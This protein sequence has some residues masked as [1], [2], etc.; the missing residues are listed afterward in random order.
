MIKAG[1]WILLMGVNAAVFATPVCEEPDPIM[2][3]ATIILTHSSVDRR[4]NHVGTFEFRNHAISPAVEISASRDGRFAGVSRPQAQVEFKDLNGTWT[5]LDMPVEEFVPG[6][7][8][9]RVAAGATATF[10]IMLFPKNLVRRDGSD[11]RVVVRLANPDACVV[12]YPFRAA[13]MRKPVSGF[14]S[15]PIP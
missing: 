5:V 15:L 11:F 4:G 2:P 7:F 13:P 8:K 14:V 10:R 6:G 3:Q 9:L 1:L 12:S